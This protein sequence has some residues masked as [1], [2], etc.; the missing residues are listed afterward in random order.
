MDLNMEKTPLHIYNNITFGSKFILQHKKLLN[1]DTIA[2]N[3]NKWIDN[4][5]G[6]MQNPPPKKKAKSLNVF[7]KSTYETENNLEEKLE[8][9]SKKYEGNSLKII[10]KFTN[11]I[12]L[13]ISFGQC[14]HAIFKEEHKSRDLFKLEEKGNYGYQDDYQ[15]TDFLDTYYLGLL[16]ND[17]SEGILTSPGLYFEINPQIE[18]EFILSYSGKLTIVDT[19]F[20]SYSDQKKYN[21]NFFHDIKLPQICLFKRI[22]LQN[23]N[24]FYIYNLKYAFS[25]FPSFKS[26]YY[27]YANRYIRNIQKIDEEPS[28]NCKIITCR[29]I[30]NSFKIHFISLNIKKKKLKEPETYSYICED[31][32]MCCKAI[33]NDSF[34]IGLRN[35]KLIKA[36]IHEFINNNIDEKNKKKPVYEYEYDITLDKYITGHMGSINVL[37]I[38]ERLGIVITGGS[39][40]KIII[41][42]LYDFE[43]LTSIKVKPKFIITMAKVSENNLLYILCFNKILE[44][45]IIF[46]YSLS[47]LKF[48]KSEYSYFTNLEFTPGGNIITLE[49]NSK[50]KIFYG[51]NLQEMDIN[52]KDEDY[53]KFSTIIQSFSDN[54]GNIGWIQFNDFKKYYGNDR[55]IISFTKEQNKKSYIYQTLKVTNISYFE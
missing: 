31:F 35:G 24:Y 53:K 36:V 47:G 15:G 55:S 17:N 42:K 16:K 6:Y 5:F 32:V 44:R 1:S 3:I 8:K 4:V 43:L 37:E 50:L 33:S 25:S 49:N 20:Y 38:E 52:E 12:N 34:I 11:K 10:K 45:T 26:P 30:D 29:H 46:G 48:A 7:P 40:N 18:K 2:L 21:W 22:K 9:L 13:I 23:N 41:R 14:P 54:D 39:D 27:L 51:Y 28:E 19:N